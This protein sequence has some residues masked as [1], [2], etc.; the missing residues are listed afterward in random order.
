MVLT[1]PGSGSGGGSGGDGGSG[2]GPAPCPE[3]NEMIEVLRVQEV[4]P[5]GMGIVVSRNGKIITIKHRELNPATDGQVLQIK[6]GEVDSKTDLIKGYSFKRQKDVYRRIKNK[7]LRGC[8]AWRIVD[9]YKVTPCEPIWKNG[10]WMP[11]FKAPGATIDYTVGVR[12]DIV[13]D[14]GADEEHN[15][16]LVGR[17]TPLLIHNFFVLPC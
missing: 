9:G 14:T 17:E 3:E 13:V 6:V 1:T 2:G 4:L 11:A 5:K 16:Y 15:Y 12:V 8:A 10:Q 7:F